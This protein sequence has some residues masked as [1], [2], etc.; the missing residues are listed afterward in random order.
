MQGY[1]DRGRLVPFRVG[2]SEEWVKRYDFTEG[3]AVT[4]HTPPEAGMRVA[5]RWDRLKD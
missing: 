1:D 3:E 2:D 5:W 4:V